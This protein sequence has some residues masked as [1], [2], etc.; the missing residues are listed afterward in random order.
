MPV[1]SVVLFLLVILAGFLP[2]FS[3]TCCYPASFEPSPPYASYGCVCIHAYDNFRVE[4]VYDPSD[5]FFNY[6]YDFCSA[7][8]AS[9][10]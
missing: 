10:E 5:P 3:R 2:A 9:C 7:M 6:A 4:F 1:L 8:F